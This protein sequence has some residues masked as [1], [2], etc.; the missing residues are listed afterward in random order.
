MVS[1]FEK[2]GSSL[3][4][5]STLNELTE[6]QNISAL[7][8]ETRAFT[9]VECSLDTGTTAQ[10]QGGDVEAQAP[11]AEADS[12]VPAAVK[13]PRSQ[14]R[15][16]FGRFTILAEVQEPKHYPRRAKWFITFVVAMAAI[17][18]P[19]GSAIFFPS[20]LQVSEDLHTTPTI[21]NLSVAMYML[22]MSIFPLWWSS[23][24]ETLGRRT[25]YITSF[26]LFLVF[27][28]LSAESKN[29]AMLI[30][31]RILAGGAAAS[32]Q[33]VGAGTIADVWEPK[34]RGQAMGVFYL[35]P[36]M[37][38]LLAPIIG[39]GLALKWGWRSTQWFLAIFGLVVLVFLFFALPETLKNRKVPAAEACETKVEQYQRPPL[40]RVRSRQ[41]VHLRTKKTVKMLKRAFLDP[42][43][44]I[45]YLRFPAVLITVYYASITFGSLYIL[46]VSLESTFNQAPYYFSTIEVGL[47]YIPNSIGYIFASIFGGRWTDSIMAREA[48]KAGRYDE[49][50]KLI[51]RPEDRMRENAWI[52]AF[53]YP[54]A[55]IWYGWAAERQVFW[56]VPL[57]A[58]F[59]FGVG[60][61]LIF[62]MATTMLTEFMPRK[63]SA[64][65]AVNNFV[66]NIF[67]CVGGVV[68]QPLIEAIGNGWLF[69]GL[70]VIAAASSVVVWAM[71]HYGPRWR[72]SMDEKMG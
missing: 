11:Q 63:S 17:A 49:N 59:F 12:I 62:S 32:V 66:R 9:P 13:V 36:L 28:I 29:I 5:K 37:G 23:F 3:D 65:V 34:E 51:Y 1:D 54:A 10:A 22:S 15:G 4:K 33:A 60:S 69:T 53:L 56:I 8:K 55:L 70:G 61:M 46:N 35:G 21:T 52:A 68:A 26:S 47:T 48:K 16:L 45:L 2:S 67:S 58:N 20:L 7:G 41:E 31:M 6:N 38:P 39:G 50:G 57:I 43:K 18:A 27:N 64:G 19:I 40:S 25:I 72:I 30:V 24:S 44:I 14:R 71:R 42:L